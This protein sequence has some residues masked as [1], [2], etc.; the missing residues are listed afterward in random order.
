M[1][2]LDHLVSAEDLLP[3]VWELVQVLVWRGVVV[4]V[5]AFVFILIVVVDF[6]IG[7]VSLHDGKGKRALLVFFFLRLLTP[8]MTLL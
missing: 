2:G 3:I 7:S 8:F 5:C 4:L 1:M 6:I